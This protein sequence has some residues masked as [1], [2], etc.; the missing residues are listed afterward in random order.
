MLLVVFLLLLLLLLLIVG[1]AK[2]GG[3]A[4]GC[5]GTS[6]KQLVGESKL[7]VDMTIAPT[8]AAQPGGHLADWQDWQPSRQVA[9]CIAMPS[10]GVESTRQTGRGAGVTLELASPA[11]L[12]GFS[13]NRLLEVLEVLLFSASSDRLI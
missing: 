12:L 5:Q 7:E 13:D 2:R 10:G 4:D 9:K 11:S 6:G 8:L 1:L 3:R